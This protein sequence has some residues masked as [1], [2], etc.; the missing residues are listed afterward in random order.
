MTT[1]THEVPGISP[2]TAFL[3]AIRRRI[4]D[5]VLDTVIAD[6][7]MH[8]FPTGEGR[9]DDAGWYSVQY[10]GHVLCGSFGDWR[11]EVREKWKSSNYRELSPAQKKE[12]NDKIRASAKQGDDDLK[13]GQAKAASKA[14]YLFDRFAWATDNPLH[15]YLARKGVK[16]CRGLKQGDYKGVD[17]L[18]IPHYWGDEIISFQAIAPDGAKRNLAGGAKGYF[19]IGDDRNGPICLAEGVATGLSIHESTGYPCYVAFDADNMAKVA[20]FLKALFPDRDFIVCAD[21]DH[22]KRA[23]KGLSVARKIAAEHGFFVAKP[24]FLDG[25]GKTDFN[26]MHAEQGAEA[27]KA[28]IEASLKQDRAKPVKPEWQAHNGGKYVIRGD[29]VYFNSEDSGDIW[30]CSPLR[31]LA[32]TRDRNTENWGRLLEWFDLDG[33]RHRWAMPQYLLKGNGEELRGELLAGGVSIQN[34]SK[35][36]SHLMTY[37]QVW[38]TDKRARCVDRVGWYG[39]T[40]VLPDRTIGEKDEIIVCQSERSISDERSQS[41]TVAEWVEHIAR[42]VSGNS[43]LVF[44][45]CLAFA[46]PLLDI[47]GEE[48]R[49]FHLLGGSSS[50]KTTALYLAAS[51]YGKADRYTRSWRATS[52]GLE[53]IAAAHND[54][55]LP[56]DE[57]SQ[58]SAKEVVRGVI[59][60]LMNGQGKTRANRTGGAR[61]SQSW[62]MLLLSSGEEG[63]AAKAGK[64]G[65][66][67]NVGE[68]LRFIEIDADVKA[69][70]F[71]TVSSKSEASTLANAL[72]SASV[73]FYGTVGNTWLENIV[74]DRERLKTAL[75]RQID[76]YTAILTAGDVSG[77]AVR[78]ARTVALVMAAGEL[79]TQYGLTGW[80]ENEAADAGVECFKDW[81]SRFGTENRE[82]RKLLEQVKALLFKEHSQFVGLDSSGRGYYP[83]RIGYFDCVN[84]VLREYL[85]YPEQFESEVC[86]GFPV[87]WAIE[88]FKKHGWLRTRGDG[89][90]K[91][92]IRGKALKLPEDRFVSMYAL[93]HD[94]IFA[95]KERSDNAG[96]Q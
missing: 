82:E 9:H 43:R 32:Y 11:T 16:P 36:R 68:E 37:L 69:G 53:G 47:V 27:V 52:N 49:G 25:T 34:N 54:S 38:K 74:R 95:D 30:V 1:G 92:P 24:R 3:D 45:I 7:K 23:N 65:V 88:V 90:N 41:G 83:M 96:I 40:Y 58:I 35:A 91:V 76:D 29:G 26:D 17:T 62:R 42:P 64:E 50:G 44:G 14:K 84:G 18:Y 51:V 72:K 8:R 63:L 61:Q 70:I 19:P 89:R 75:S 15:P 20:A 86:K 60:H 59:Y 85:F 66:S 87:K 94:V 4:P 12:V 71:E 48:S 67:V 2:E 5:A 10:V 22:E 6:G 33:Q 56:L 13:Q 28:C 57:F 77:Q 93:R 79:A 73:R 46:S 31:I 55:F 78:V 21:D 80:G 81:L 39:D